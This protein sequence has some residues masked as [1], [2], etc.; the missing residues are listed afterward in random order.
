MERGDMKSEYRINAA[1]IAVLL[2]GGVSLF[3]GCAVNCEVKKVDTVTVSADF[4]KFSG[5]T[6]KPLHGINN[7]PLSLNKPIPELTEAGI[8]FVRLHDTGGAYGG[9]V[10]VDIPN[11]FPDFDADENDPANYHFEFTDAYIKQLVASGCQVF[12]RLGITIENNYRIRALRTAPPKDFAKW[13]RICEKVIRHYNEGWAN[14]FKYGIKY[15]EIWNEPE[16]PPMWSGT[17]EQFFELYKVASTYLKKQFPD[18][19][20]GGYASC[21]FYA[22]NYPENKTYAMFMQWANEFVAFCAK[23]KLPLDFFSYHRYYDDPEKI[24]VEAEYARNLLDKHGFNKTECIFNEWNFTNWLGDQYVDMRTEL[25]ASMVAHMLILLQRLP[26]DKAMYYQATPNSGYGGWYEFP[27]KK[28]TRTYYA[29]KSFNSLYKL[30]REVSCTISGKGIIGFAAAK[31]SAAAVMLA[32]SGKEPV[33]VSLDLLNIPGQ[34]KRYQADKKHCFELLPYEKE[35]V[36]PAHSFV[37]LEYNSGT[38]HKVDALNEKGNFAG[39][40]GVD[41][42]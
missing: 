19:S 16:N 36:M 39:L 11:I 21:G 23:E 12:Y 6:I 29:F 31:D 15:W 35:F 32:N 3:S 14:G 26:V 4:S 38:L 8:P 9:S 20:F 40:D 37:L 25:G 33:R 10:Y 18:L 5:K 27:S 28:L 42:K 41:K 22:L 2:M 17:R 1:V 24:I 7:S 30:G 13:A 34:G